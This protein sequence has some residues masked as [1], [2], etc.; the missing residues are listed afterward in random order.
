MQ[1]EYISKL[2][3]EVKPKYRYE[4]VGS[5]RSCN[6][7]FYFIV[8][9][10]RVRVCKK[11]FKATLDIND[12]PI[13]T[14]L[15]KTND[16]FIEGDNRGKHGNH[17]V[18]NPSVRQD[19][20]DFINSIP[21]IESHYL[22]EQSTREYIDGGKSIAGMHR[23][24][25]AECKSN[26]KNYGNLTLFSRIFN[27]QFNISFFVP[28]KDQCELCTAYSNAAED[29]KD[30]LQ[31]QYENHLKEKELCREEKKNDKECAEKN[32]KLVVAVYDLQAV[33]PAPRGD[34][35]V[36]FLQIKN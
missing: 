5:T 22:R 8:N 3:T 1:R 36:F 14:V 35:S 4:R 31:D 18:I 16:G 29:E 11:F 21:R 6:H 34:V 10:T 32:D 19:I 13:R 23:D 15:R 28:K 17:K 26:N 9:G 30:K 2:I 27:E 7:A 25:V 20:H 24:Y 33:L 12:R